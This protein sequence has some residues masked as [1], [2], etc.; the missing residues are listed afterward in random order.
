MDP[1]SITASVVGIVM[2][3]LDGTRLLLDDLQQLKDAP[4]VVKRLV[5]KGQR[6]TKIG[7]DLRSAEYCNRWPCLGA[8]VHR[9]RS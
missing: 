4:K 7:N 1:L 6:L 2:P 9:L 8:A 5:E 3:A